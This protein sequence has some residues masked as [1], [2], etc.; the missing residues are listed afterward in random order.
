MKMKT[1]TKPETK[2]ETNPEMSRQQF[3]RTLAGIGV[4]TLGASL[5]IACGSVEDDMVDDDM[6]PPGTPSCVANGSSVTIGTNHGHAL[7]VAMADV[8]AG[9][10][11]TYDITGTSLHAHSVTVT[12]AQ[13]AML[14]AGGS[15][16]ITVV[17]T[18]G[19]NHTHSVMVTCA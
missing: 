2:T 13:F 17:S 14:A 12:A 19:A 1:E 8:S 16:S 18:T 6:E 4:G 3:L 11:K 15:A 7:T 9:A 10:E 5:L